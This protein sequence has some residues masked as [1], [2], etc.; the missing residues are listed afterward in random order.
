[1][2]TQMYIDPEKAFPAATREMVHQK[3]KENE[4]ARDE[5]LV[6]R[7]NVKNDVDEGSVRRRQK[8][9]LLT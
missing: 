4:V 6:R 2:N 5:M 9:D 3:K 1:M 8:R 7:L